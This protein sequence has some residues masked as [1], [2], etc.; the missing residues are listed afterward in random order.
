MSAGLYIEFLAMKLPNMC[1]LMQM[2]MGIQIKH[3]ICHISSIKI[4]NVGDFKHCWMYVL[5]ERF[6]V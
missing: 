4:T 5:S 2:Q 6:L 3:F 1:V